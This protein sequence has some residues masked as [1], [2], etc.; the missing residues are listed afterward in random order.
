MYVENLAP[1]S[2][3]KK[4]KTPAFSLS[5]TPS[6]NMLRHLALCLAAVAAVVSLAAS[7]SSNTSNDRY[8]YNADE[9]E[10]KTIYELARMVP[11]QASINSHQSRYGQ[12]FLQRI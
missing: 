7:S 12:R 1:L 8:G 4:Y 10:G 6:G 11:A 5:F 3:F 9:L 2:P